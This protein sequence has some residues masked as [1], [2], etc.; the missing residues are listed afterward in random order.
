MEFR[1]LLSLAMLAVAGVVLTGCGG[2]VSPS[3]AAALKVVSSS[4]AD[5]VS[6]GDALVE[7]IVPSEHVAELTLGGV[8]RVPSKLNGTDLPADTF[9]RREGGRILG[10]VQGLREGKNQLEVIVAGR[11]SR[12]EVTNFPAAGPVFSGAR[13]SPWICA[14]VSA[15]PVTVSAPDDPSLTGTATTRV[16]GLNSDPTDEACSTKVEYVYYYQPRSKLGSGCT[17]TVTGANPCFVQYNPASRPDDA[18]IA[19][20]TNDRGLT[21]KSL[22]RLEKGTINRSL[23]NVLAYFDPAQ[24][25]QP[26]APQQGWNGKLLWKM[27]ASTSAGR[28]QS[29]PSATAIFDV[30]ALTAGHMTANT[31]LTEHSANNNELL[32]AETLMMIKEHIVETYG[33]IRFTMA[34][35][36][37]GGSMMQTVAASVMPGLLDGLLPSSSFPDAVST[38]METQDCSLLRGLYFLTP[39]GSALT[40]EQRAAITGHPVG[41]DGGAYC[42][43]WARSW[44]GSFDGSKAA[45]CLGGFP[46]SIVYDPVTRRNGVRC[47]LNDVQRSQWGTF[48]DTD[49]NTKTKW[50]YDNVGVQYGLNALK[51]KAISPE[52]FVQ[53]NEGIGSLSADAVWS[54]GSPAAPVQ[55]ASRGQAQ[56]DVLPTIYK[57]GILAD[58]RQLA[59]VAMIDLRGD[60]GPDIHMPWRSL[61]E[62]DRLVR[63]N[64]HSNNQV[65]RGFMG[66]TGAAAIRQAFQMMDRWLTAI[67]RDRSGDPIET[68]VVRN[69]PSDVTDACFASNGNADADV[70]VSKNVGFGSVACPVT[71]SMTSPR[72][73]AGGPLAENVFKCQLKPLNAN[74][75]DYGG[76]LFSS[77]QQSRLFK[78]FG[79]GVCDW[80]KPG[81]GQTQAQPTITFKAG[82]GGEALPPAPVWESPL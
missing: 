69:R 1:I 58:G 19:D 66:N 4:R 11:T 27:G 34:D 5:L 48:V 46:A 43:A 6:G 22:L 60:L 21:V 8:L 41:T 23:Y 30:N 18:D 25:W 70:D 10:L 12:L 2:G 80:S 76:V 47:S 36:G 13:F 33:P 65:I 82:P 53:L 56:V 42:N 26:W 32:G 72:V 16:S 38:W 44:M 49:G 17:L 9:L 7:V 28:H 24:P 77:A 3:S 37:S 29:A 52:Q 14:R 45:N 73:V 79:S 31:T 64:G 57:S 15:T 20:F 67:E 74:D 59:K 39:A 81:V 40:S 71:F 61:S 50:P 35:G 55:V 68:K 51:S 63:A 75:P 78:V 62:R 54:G